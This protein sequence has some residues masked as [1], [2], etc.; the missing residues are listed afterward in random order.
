[1]PDGRQIE[2]LSQICESCAGLPAPRRST[3]HDWT[4]SADAA[5]LA[6]I[7]LGAS[8]QRA[9]RVLSNPDDAIGTGRPVEGLGAEIDESLIVFDDATNCR[10]VGEDSH[11]VSVSYAAVGIVALGRARPVADTCQQAGSSAYDC[12]S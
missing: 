10:I 9:I 7:L 11:A 2:S 4:A 6:S 5:F 3:A 8:I 1:M 12:Q